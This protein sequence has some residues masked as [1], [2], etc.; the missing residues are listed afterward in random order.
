MDIVNL[1]AVEQGLKINLFNVCLAAVVAVADIVLLFMYSYNDAFITV[2]VA[3]IVISITLGGIELNQLLRVKHDI[4]IIQNSEERI[5]YSSDCVCC[6]KDKLFSFKTISKSMVSGIY[7][8][9]ANK[10]IL[11][12]R[13][14]GERHHE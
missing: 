13:L 10:T 14:V 5:R 8:D 2:C 6:G 1:D 12:P 9:V 4:V 7:M 11:I 3:M